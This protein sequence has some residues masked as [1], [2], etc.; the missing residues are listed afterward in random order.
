MKTA[1]CLMMLAGCN[2]MQPSEFPS[3]RYCHEIT[4]ERI[5]IDIKI[6]ATCRAPAAMV[7]F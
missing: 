5:G 6:V 7:L 1:L 4:Y 2:L 3:L